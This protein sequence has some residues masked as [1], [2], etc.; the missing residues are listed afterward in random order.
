MTIVGPGGIG[1]TSVALAI[2]EELVAAYQDGVWLIDLASLDHPRLLAAALAA[3][4]ALDIGSE[5][6][7]SSLITALR[8]RQMLLFLD[9]RG[10]ARKRLLRLHRVHRVRLVAMPRLRTDPVWRA[11]AEVRS[12]HLAAGQRAPSFFRRWG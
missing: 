10:D 3:A 9:R 12:W 7:L 1:K 5:N 6:P 8:D 11:I 2:A 4:L